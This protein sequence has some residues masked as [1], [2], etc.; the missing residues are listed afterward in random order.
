MVSMPKQSKFIGLVFTKIGMP[1]AWLHGQS[2][3][4]PVQLPQVLPPQ[5]PL[6]MHPSPQ[7]QQ[8]QQQQQ[9]QQTFSQPPQIGGMFASLP[10]APSFAPQPNQQFSGMGIDPSAFNFNSNMANNPQA[11]DLAELQRMLSGQ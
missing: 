7:L 6:Q 9:L 8:Q 3:Q 2:L 5:P 10:P 1:E 4:T 11:M